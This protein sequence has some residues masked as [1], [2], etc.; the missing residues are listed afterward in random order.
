MVTERA[1]VNSIRSKTEKK[2]IRLPV[3][4]SGGS[5]EPA[6]NGWP[7]QMITQRHNP[8]YRS[9]RTEIN[10]IINSGIIYRS[11]D[12]AVFYTLRIKDGFVF[13]LKRVRLINQGIVN[14]KNV[15]YTV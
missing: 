7:R 12:Y 8:A 13:A 11:V 10:D 9:A 15:W 2:A 14:M 4:L 1:H 5:L 6:G 3:V